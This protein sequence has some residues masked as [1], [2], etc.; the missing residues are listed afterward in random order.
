MVRNSKVLSKNEK[1]KKLLGAKNE[2][3]EF[4]GA[5]ADADDMEAV[6]RSQAADRRQ[7]H[8]IIEE[9]E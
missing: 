5:E 7:L 8:E 4:S 2:D 9:E 1:M 3:V 6:A